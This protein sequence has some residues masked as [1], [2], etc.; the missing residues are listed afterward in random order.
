MSHPVLAATAVIDEALKTVADTNPA[1]MATADKASALRELVTLESRLA[2]LRMRIL[3]DADDLA[4]ELRRTR[5]RRVARR[6]HPHALRGRARRPPPRC[7][8]RSSVAHARCGAARR[9]GEH[10]P[11][12]GDRPRARRAARRGPDRRAGPCRGG[13]DRARGP[14]RPEAARADRTTHPHRGRSGPRRRGRG[15]AARRPGGG[16]S[17]ADAVEAAP[18]RRR[19]HPRVRPHP[20][21]S[22]H[23]VRDL[24]R[25]V[26]QPAPRHGRR[27]PGD[28][29]SCRDFP[30]R[31]AS[32]RPSA[33]CWRR[34]IRS[35]CPST[36]VTPPR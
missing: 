9:P 27:R 29:S 7:R 12:V 33:S 1:F 11:G 5:R 28:R 15:Q 14:L 2:E 30:I 16:G 4:A 20:R 25:G 13:A 17:P 24:P 6:R 19:H 35:G 34:W 22:G 32:A 36:V 3:A 23:P 18:P 21:C 10:R 8:T 31:A 26:R